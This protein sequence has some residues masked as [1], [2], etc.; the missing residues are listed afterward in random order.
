M[1]GRRQ[2][3]LD[4]LSR[5]LRG[6]RPE[7]VQSTLK[8]FGFHLDRQRGS[9]QTW[10]REDGRKVMVVEARPVKRW[11][12]EEVIEICAQILAEEGEES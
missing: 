10:R 5:S 1:P 6:A 9:H 4:K 11:Y 7:L 3:Q 2:R 8:A 12:V